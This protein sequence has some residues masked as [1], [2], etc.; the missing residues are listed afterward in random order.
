MTPVV[1]DDHHG[2]SAHTFAE[3]RMVIPFKEKSVTLHVIHV[4]RKR[5]FTASLAYVS[6]RS[7]KL[8]ILEARDEF[9]NLVLTAVGEPEGDDSLIALINFI[10][11]NLI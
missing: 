9:I 1:Y 2:S 10:N 4:G 7:K 11:V 5:I 3:H 6:I 8:H